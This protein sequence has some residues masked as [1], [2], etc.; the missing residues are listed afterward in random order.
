MRELFCSEGVCFLDKK[1][2]PEDVKLQ[3]GLGSG[4]HFDNTNSDFITMKGTSASVG[5]VKRRKTINRQRGDGALKIIQTRAKASRSRKVKNFALQSQV[6][7]GKKNQKGLGSPK[8]SIQ[9]GKGHKKNQRGTGFKVQ[10]RQQKGKGKKQVQRGKGVKVQTRPQKG[11]GKKQVQRGKGVKGTR[12]QKGRGINK[13]RTNKKVKSATLSVKQLGLGHR[14]RKN[15]STKARKR[16]TPA[17]SNKRIPNR[18]GSA[19]KAKKQIKR[20]A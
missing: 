7:Q 16:H 1:N 20:K 2:V 19:K 13:S 8:G 15:S 10:T 9:K 5:Q 11:K 14:K 4:G 3:L 17:K 18:K 12:R 6:G